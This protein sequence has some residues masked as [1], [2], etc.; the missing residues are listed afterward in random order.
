MKKLIVCLTLFSSTTILQAGRSKK[1]QQ[2]LQQPPATF[3]Q[4]NNDTEQLEFQKL[5]TDGNRMP[6]VDSQGQTEEIVAAAQS[7]LSPI[8][9]QEE[10][11]TISEQ[12]SSEGDD[13]FD[14][15]FSSHSYR[16]SSPVSSLP[17][18]KSSRKFLPEQNRSP[19]RQPQQ[20]TPHSSHDFLDIDGFIDSAEVKKAEQK[21]QERALEKQTPAQ[22][23]LR[24]LER[25]GFFKAV[26][27][28]KQLA[29]Y[30]ALSDLQRIQLLDNNFKLQ[31]FLTTFDSE[32]SQ[33]EWIARGLG[34]AV[35]SKSIDSVTRILE[36]IQTHK[37]THLVPTEHQ[38]RAALLLQSHYTKT[39]SQI[40]PRTQRVAKPGDL[41]PRSQ[42]ADATFAAILESF[43][44]KPNDIEKIPQILEKLKQK[45]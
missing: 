40:L 36:I 9:Q 12:H 42:T 2:E 17:N 43:G 6:S 4:N 23:T 18:H 35:D 34:Q 31:E 44:H 39:I 20:K 29:E 25:I 27:K 13:D 26:A 11:P 41:S 33:G 8:Q 16:R 5:S 28:A 37:L 19:L 30:L 32:E 7:T 24:A 22:A 3:V 45:N 38:N 21:E 10:S 14:H 15:A 1:K